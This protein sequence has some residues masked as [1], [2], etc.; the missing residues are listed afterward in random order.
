LL[1][2]IFSIPNISNL[3]WIFSV[4]AVIYLA[5]LKA[6]REYVTS[7]FEYYENNMQGTLGLLRAIRERGVKNLV[8][9]SSATIYGDR[10]Y[11]PIDEVNSVMPKNPYGKRIYKLS[12]YWKI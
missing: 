8:F 6:V 10:H 7:A 3:Q 12:R 4:G 1:E 5:G 11:L 2:E 9:S